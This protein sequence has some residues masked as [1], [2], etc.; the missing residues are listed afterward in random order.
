VTGTVQVASFVI[1]R[2]ADRALDRSRHVIR[3]LSETPVRRQTE[4][5]DEVEEST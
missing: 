1:A 5:D 3:G 4:R 2:W